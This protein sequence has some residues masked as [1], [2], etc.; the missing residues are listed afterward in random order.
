MSVWEREYGA[1]TRGHIVTLLRGGERS[2]DEL[3]TELG[4][5]DNAVRAAG[6]IF[7]SASRI[8]FRSEALAA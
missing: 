8:C 7:C 6:E 2:V 3:A 4:L 5:T 1:T